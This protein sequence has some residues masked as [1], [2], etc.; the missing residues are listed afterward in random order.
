[1]LASGQLKKFAVIQLREFV[2]NVVGGKK[3]CVVVGCDVTAQ[4][5][6]AIG[7]PQNIMNPAGGP[8]SGG[9]QNRPAPPQNQQA[10]HQRNQGQGF[11][12]NQSGSNYGGGGGNNQ[13]KS[14]CGGNDNFQPVS[15]LN[16][17]QSSWRIKVRVTKKDTM[18]HWS[19]QKGDGKLFG[20]D[21]LDAEGTEIRAVCFNDAAEK[22]YSVFEKDRVYIIS[23]GSVRMARK[24][25][26]HI[27]NDYSITLN[28]DS[29]VVLVADGQIMGQKYRFT[30]VRDIERVEARS[31]VDVVGVVVAVG[32][33]STILSSKS[34]KE[35]K[36][37]NP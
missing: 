28:T 31:F 5:N 3:I 7:Q 9:N 33:L 24:G 6:A 14:R 20:L 32:P 4:Q 12:Q 2:C 18:R 25:F 35:I 34:Q 22:F 19:N 21:L 1:M 29:E 16:P 10:F 23:R 17:Y 11:G 37:R 30:K 26:S 13:N 8:Q 27:Q 36:R 15:S